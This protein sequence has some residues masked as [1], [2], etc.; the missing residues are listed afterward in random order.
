MQYAPEI[1]RRLRFGCGECMLQ[2]HA[3]GQVDHDLQCAHQLFL[4]CH[5]CLRDASA[6]LSSL[7][8]IVS[9][10]GEPHRLTGK[11]K[12]LVLGHEFSG[13]VTGQVPTYQT[14]GRATR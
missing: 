3:S 9:A 5:R 12:P 6:N 13:I 8:Y 2:R 1:Q 11:A 4:S 14:S 7:Q 10:R